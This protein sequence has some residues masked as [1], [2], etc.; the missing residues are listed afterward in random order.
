M[1]EAIDYV[2]NDILDFFRTINADK[3]H[4]LPPGPFQ[5]QRMIHYNPQ[6]KA[7]FEEAIEELI[8]EGLVERRDGNIFLTHSPYAEPCTG[9]RAR[10]VAKA[11]RRALR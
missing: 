6:Q 8:S 9:V 11:E 1:R 4:V 5:V 2:K 10:K 7:A 3:G